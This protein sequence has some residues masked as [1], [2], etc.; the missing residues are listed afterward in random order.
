MF[1]DTSILPDAI[2]CLVLLDEVD[3][4]VVRHN[5]VEIVLTNHT[6]EFDELR[7][8]FG[9]LLV[10][11]DSFHNLGSG[12]CT[13]FRC[14]H[15]ECAIDQILRSQTMWFGRI[16]IPHTVS[17]ETEGF[18]VGIVLS[19]LSLSQRFRC[20]PPWVRFR[21]FGEHTDGWVV[22]RTMIVVLFFILTFLD[23]LNHMRILSGS[24]LMGNTVILLLHLRLP[25][26][27]GCFGS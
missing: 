14:W 9:F 11:I 4:I 23:R 3:D 1:E 5:L 2:P 12:P 17:L 7:M 22:K 10:E 25:C 16:R 13:V 15:K 8:V 18:V 20:V 19:R 26:R 21:G 6:T 27:S 24:F